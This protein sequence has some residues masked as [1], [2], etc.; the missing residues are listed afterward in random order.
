MVEK[1]GERGEGEER[2]SQ[3]KAIAN[4]QEKDTLQ[5]EWR[6]HQNF[7]EKTDIHQIYTFEKDKL[8][9]KKLTKKE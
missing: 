4:K 8:I 3:E 7:R 6:G 2:E 9:Q 1:G 5:K